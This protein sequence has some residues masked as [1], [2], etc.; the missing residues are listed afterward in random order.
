MGKKIFVS[1]KY[2]DKDVESLEYGT[3]V[4]TYVDKLENYFSKNDIYKG[5]SDDE[6]L[7]ALSDDVI[8]NKLKDR[9]YDSSVT[10]VMISPNM[11]EPRRWEKSQWIPWEI[12]YSL[13]EMTRND[14]TSHSNAMLAVVLP[15]KNGSY[16]YFIE[17][18]AYG[19]SY[20]T[21]ILFK[22]LRSNMFNRK[23]KQVSGEHS[24]IKPVK[25]S[26]FIKNAQSYIDKA[27][28]IQSNISNYIITK[29]V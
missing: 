12:S 4:R 28:E 3:T 17:E 29:E 1:Y 7:S 27:I 13:K 21:D 20:K 14:R 18:T 11:K 9:I 10:L 16:S 22:I 19:I 6:D 2:A 25:W 23:D 8:W 24:Y 26:T 5:E 15:N